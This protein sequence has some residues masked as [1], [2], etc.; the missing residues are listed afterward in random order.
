M[1]LDQDRR[2]SGGQRVPFEA[3]VVVASQKGGAGAYECEAVDVSETGM[4]L[5]TAYL[6]EI[7]QTLSFRFDSGSSEI[8]TEGVVV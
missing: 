8:V 3:L 2:T 5:R 4:H 7:G 1:S 6:P